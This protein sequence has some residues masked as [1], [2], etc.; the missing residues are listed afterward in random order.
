M[1][2]KV[3]ELTQQIYQEGVAKAEAQA[4]SI[5]KEAQAE[6]QKIISGAKAESESIRKAAQKQ[7]ED[8]QA[9]VGA[10]LK[11]T[12]RQAIGSLQQELTHLVATDL[13]HQAVTPAFEQPQF[14]Q[15]LM[16]TLLKQWWDHFKSG[17]NVQITLPEK[18]AEE[19]QNFVD[20]SLQTYL[21]KGFT[22]K[23]SAQLEKGFQVEALQEGIKISFTQADF[24]A[25]FKEMARPRIYQM[26][27]PEP[28]Q[29]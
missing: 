20:Q 27:F 13:S 12:V 18:E 19:F 29:S 5:K 1:E 25:F 22:L 6:A 26:L 10:E 3:Q 7:A 16:E 9:Q 8:L 11:L 23:Y 17:Q 4:A 21:E 2:K 28:P 24:E 15:N 14:I